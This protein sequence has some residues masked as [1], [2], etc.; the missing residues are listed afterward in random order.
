MSGQFGGGQFGGGGGGS[1]T[2]PPAPGLSVVSVGSGTVT[3][4]YTAAAGESSGEIDFDDGTTIGTPVATSGTGNYV[5]SGLANDTMYYFTSRAQSGGAWSGP[6]VTVLATPH[7]SRLTNLYASAVTVTEQLLNTCT[8]NGNYEVITAR[9]KKP[10]AKPLL[11]YVHRGNMFTGKR[12]N[13]T[14]YTHRT[15]PVE[16]QF[17]YR[18]TD[19]I[20]SGLQEDNLSQYIEEAWDALNLLRPSELPTAIDFFFL[21]EATISSIDTDTSEVTLAKPPASSEI[22]GALRVEWEF[23]VPNK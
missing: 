15:Y 21:T 5:I 1:G 12:P 20:T 9:R 7:R 14:G 4:L 11:L 13:T 17:V 3:L 22:E 23:W 18:K 8:F 16:I 6:S 19:K 10:Q 2:T